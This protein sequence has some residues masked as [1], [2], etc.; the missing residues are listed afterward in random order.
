MQKTGPLLVSRQIGCIPDNDQAVLG[1]CYCHI[2]TVVLLN[3][4]AWLRP[5]HSDKDN[6]KLST[7]WAVDRDDLLIHT[8]F[9]EF[10]HNGILLRIVRCDHENV[11]LR[12]FDFWYTVDF[13]VYLLHFIKLVDAQIGHVINGL[14]FLEVNKWGTFELFH[15]VSDIHEKEGTPW[16]KEHF[17]NVAFIAT[18]DFV[19]VEE[20]I[21][22]LHQLLVHAILSVQE[23]V[24]VASVNQSWKH[25]CWPIDF[26][27]KGWT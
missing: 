18:L 24:G 12:K 22:H 17:L 14:N 15:A 10:V 16:V 4:V 6:V 26:E 2:N 27:A 25:R 20:H 5:D 1:S 7:L 8:L 11:A 21:G 3:K 19:I 23:W 13:L 9:D